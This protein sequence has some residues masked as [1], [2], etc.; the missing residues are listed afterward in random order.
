MR[1]EC[2]PVDVFSG[3]PGLQPSLDTHV[4]RILLAM[5]P[6]QHLPPPASDLTAQVSSSLLVAPAEWTVA[7]QSPALKQRWHFRA[8]TAVKV[9]TPKPESNHL[10]ACVQAF[11]GTS[12]LRRNHRPAL[13]MPSIASVGSEGQSEIEPAPQR[14]V[15]PEAEVGSL[16]CSQAFGFRFSILGFRIWLRL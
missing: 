9:H 7:D 2:H 1:A 6:P 12:P 16:L 4:S 10:P 15:Q 8:L 13:S 11:Q 14:G 5:T 3:R